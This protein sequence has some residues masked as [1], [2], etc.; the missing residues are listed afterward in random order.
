LLVFVFTFGQVKCEDNAAYAIGWGF[1][2]LAF[3]AAII[4][5][6]KH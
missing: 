4:L 5:A 6:I 1:W 3:I 2:I